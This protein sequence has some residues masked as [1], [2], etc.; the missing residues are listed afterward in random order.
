MACEALRSR[1]EVERGVR[2]L[3]R[4]GGERN[5]FLFQ[6]FRSNAGKDLLCQLSIRDKIE[7]RQ[8]GAHLV[9]TGLVQR[10][11]LT[12]AV[13]GCNSQP[14]VLDAMLMQQ[15]RDGRGGIERGW[16]LLPGLPPGSMRIVTHGKQ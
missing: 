14:G 15:S 11:E 2:L 4:G 3:L 7:E 13:L 10:V 8:D 1:G 16:R 5:Q 12:P 6:D 9:G